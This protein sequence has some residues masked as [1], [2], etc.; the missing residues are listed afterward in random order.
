MTSAQDAQ[1]SV[2]TNS[3]SQGSFNP[4]K[5]ITLRYLNPWFKPFSSL[6]SERARSF[7]L[8]ENVKKPLSHGFQAFLVLN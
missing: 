8:Q 1:I 2:T 6:S 7:F 5:Q 4:D 3:P